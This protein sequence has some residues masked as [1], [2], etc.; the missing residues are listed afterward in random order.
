M[1]E[2]EEGKR[3]SCV[4]NAPR[5]MSKES[6]RDGFFLKCACLL[7]FWC[8]FVCFCLCACEFSVVVDKQRDIFIFLISSRHLASLL[9]IFLP[10][11]VPFVYHCAAMLLCPLNMGEEPP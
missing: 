6:K 10:P 7:S 8:R 9:H 5:A 3:T 4:L 1:Q 2:E 11:R